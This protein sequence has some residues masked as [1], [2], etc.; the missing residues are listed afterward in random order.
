MCECQI[1]LTIPG[2]R[3][4]V[5]MRHTIILGVSLLALGTAPVMAADIPVKAAPVT[6]IAAPAAYNWTGLYTASSVGVQRWKI[7]GTYVLFPT[8]DHNTR[9]TRVIFGS[10]AGYQ[11]QFGNFVLGVEAGYNTGYNPS[12]AGSNSISADCLGGTGPANRT[13]QSRVRNYWTFGGKVGYAWDNFMVYG[14]GGYA[15]GR[16]D[17][18]T[19]VTS[20]GALTS[21]TTARHGGWYA[22]AG[23]DFYVTKL[24][25]SDLIL[26]VEYQHVEFGRVTHVDTL[27]VALPGTNDRRMRATEDV[28]RAKATFK[29]NFGPG[30]VV[31]RY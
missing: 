8:S 10:H 25:W 21:D 5:T 23:F 4:G 14:T 18:N 22:G 3:T 16:I 20:T 9:A 6:P 11:H 26:G 24:W 29:Y 7:D 15:N 17:T 2:E 12:F 27:G 28:I 31:A 1:G 13:C 19:F 30:P